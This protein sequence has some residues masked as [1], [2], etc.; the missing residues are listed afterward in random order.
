M[1]Y[2]KEGKEVRVGRAYGRVCRRKLRARLVQ[3][4]LKASCAQAWGLLGT[5]VADGL[6]GH[7]S[8]SGAQPASWL[9]IHKWKQGSSEVSCTWGRQY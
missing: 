2:F 7:Y 8:S 4:C 9:H 1:C 6:L 5:E 3:D